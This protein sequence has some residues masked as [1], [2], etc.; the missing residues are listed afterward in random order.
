MA[1][2]VKWA[3]FPELNSLHN[4]VN[5]LFEQAVRNNPANHLTEWVPRA[6]IYETDQALVM[7]FDLPGVQLADVDIRIEKDTL[8]I[9]GER[10]LSAQPES[11]RRVERNAGSFT[12]VFSLPEFVDQEKIAANLS[13]GVLSLT[14]PKREET[15]PKQIQ[16]QVKTA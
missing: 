15:K 16:V 11:Y 13:N 10:H 8:T 2:L 12:R 6:D 3:A 5:H 7:E 1:T 9:R 4:Q 14:L